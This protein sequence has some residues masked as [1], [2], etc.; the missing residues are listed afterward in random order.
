MFG[1]DG[2]QTSIR[3]NSIPKFLKTKNILKCDE[4]L[5]RKFHYINSFILSSLDFGKILGWDFLISSHSCEEME[6]WNGEEWRMERP[7]VSDGGGQR[8]ALRKTSI[9]L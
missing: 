4:I 9:Y 1:E 2:V 7:G 3:E 6:E 5:K 8:F